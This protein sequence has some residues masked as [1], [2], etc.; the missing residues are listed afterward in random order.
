MIDHIAIWY[1]TLSWFYHTNGK[2]GQETPVAG[3]Q[4]KIIKFNQCRVQMSDTEIC[5]ILP[6]V[7][8]KGCIH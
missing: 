3:T 2:R 5:E 8:F 6:W 4:I 1:I 7:D